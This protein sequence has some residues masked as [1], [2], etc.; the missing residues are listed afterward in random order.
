MTQDR[1]TLRQKLTKQVVDTAP[2]APDK[3]A[4]IRDSLIGG[5]YLKVG[6]HTKT[7]CLKRDIEGKT[8]HYTIGRYTGDQ[9]GV[10]CEAARQEAIRLLAEPAR[11]RRE[12]MT[13]RQ[14][15]DLYNA[16]NAKGRKGRPRAEKTQSRYAQ[17]ERSGYLATWMDRPLSSITRQEVYDRHRAITTEV[18]AGKYSQRDYARRTGKTT[19]DDVMRWFR[20]IYNRAMRADESLPVNPCI[21]V[22]W[23]NVKAERTAIPSAKL[24]AWLKGVRAIT[25]PVRRDYRLFV[26][27]TGMR[28]ESAA[29][30]R[31]DDINFNRRVLN[32]PKPK[33]GE[34]RAFEL[35]L[36]D[37]LVTL[38]KDRQRGNPVLRDELMIPAESEEWVFPAY[39]KTGHITEPRT[40]IEGVP[41]SIHD[42][43]RTFIT[44]AESLDLSPYVIGALVNHRQ[45]TGSVT[46]GY[47]KHEVERLREPM[48]RI[49]DR[50]REEQR[51]ADNPAV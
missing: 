7:F 36:S 45:P 47:I 28:R 9:R 46:A 15:I 40:E 6:K 17:F 41:F 43:R 1:A 2:F 49:T 13:L 31:W 14:A 39:S 16:S 29:T 20:A 11:L 35:P 26:L 30:V 32:V 48:Q 51:K 38:L 12:G 24:A 4:V 19:A 21:N 5:F 10:T 34:E 37:Y 23:W 18:V 42:L 3:Y 44:V 8:T 25:N 22:E 33:G 50:L 27:F